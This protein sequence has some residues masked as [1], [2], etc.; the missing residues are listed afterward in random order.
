MGVVWKGHHLGLD[1]PVAIKLMRNI[2]LDNPL[3]HYQ[4]L[5][6]EARLTARL[7]HPGIVRVLDYLEEG[8]HQAIV[9]ELIEGTT[10]SSYL[11]YKERLDE[12]VALLLAFHICTSLSVAH[13]A[14]ILHRDLKPSNILI[15]SDGTVKLGD[16]GL[17]RHLHEVGAEKARHILGTPHYMA[18]EFFNGSGM[19]DQ[20][21]D[22]YSLGVILYEML[23]GSPPFEGSTTQVI[24]AQQQQLPRLD[25]I[26]EGTRP[27]LARLLEKDP[28]RRIFDALEIKEMVRQRG[29]QL[30]GQHLPNWI[31]SLLADEQDFETRA[32]EIL[33]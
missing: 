10:L 26:P 25:R 4:S 3:R 13:R 6:R 15:A 20:R 29:L 12:R 21:C 9:M 11:R 2:P 31:P 27:I 17:A 23:T 28:A 18:P 1:L 14:G 5:R 30:D 24:Q 32:L 19:T 22:N 8:I 7:N 16:F 33:V